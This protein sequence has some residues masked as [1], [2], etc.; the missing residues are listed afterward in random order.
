[1][2]DD[3]SLTLESNGLLDFLPAPISTENENRNEE[4]SADNLGLDSTALRGE[5]S[6][7]RPSPHRWMDN[8]GGDP[9]PPDYDEEPSD[10][11]DEIEGIMER[12]QDS[13][14]RNESRS[15]M[16]DMMNGDEDQEARPI[17][18]CTFRFPRSHD[19]SRSH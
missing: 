13:M 7:S 6:R 16:D 3:G 10:F 1:M 11:E 9:P 14:S 17:A 19:W 12:E 8:G 4:D 5:G 15:I 2:G 18:S